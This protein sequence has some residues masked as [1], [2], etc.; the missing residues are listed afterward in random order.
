M[1]VHVQA[2]PYPIAEFLLKTY[3]RGVFYAIK[4]DM[5]GYKVGAEDHPNEVIPKSVLVRLSITDVF[6]SI[7]PIHPPISATQHSRTLPARTLPNINGFG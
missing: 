4:P 5:I 2:Q 6:H 7:T 3:E 1:T